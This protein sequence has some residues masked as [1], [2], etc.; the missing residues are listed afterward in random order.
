M[1][2]IAITLV[3]L[4]VIGLWIFNPFDVMSKT[5]S[6]HQITVL[7]QV[8]DKCVG[9]SESA[10]A[11]IVPIIE[12]QKLELVSRKANV[13]LRCMNDHGFVENPAWIQYAKPIAQKDADR[14][15]ISYDEALEN[16]KRSQML[17]FSSVSGQPMFWAKSK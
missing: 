3:V 5:S 16:L 1:K 6:P 13:V 8:G 9:I 12:F 2:Y 7:E 14:S 4:G 11:T 10:T 15:R 17:I